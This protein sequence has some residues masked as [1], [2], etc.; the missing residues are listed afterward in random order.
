MAE[1]KVEGEKN[2]R[3]WKVG[4]RESRNQKGVEKL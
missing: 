1:G 2:Q 3:S 4:K